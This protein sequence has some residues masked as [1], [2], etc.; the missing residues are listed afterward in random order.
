MRKAAGIFLMAALALAMATTTALPPTVV[1]AAT[2]SFGRRSRFLP[3]LD[4]SCSNEAP[5][6]DPH[7]FH[8]PGVECCDGV[9][10]NTEFN[11]NHCGWCNYGCDSWPW[12]CCYGDCVNTQD[13]FENCGS[14][15]NY[16]SDAGCFNGV[17]GYAV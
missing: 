11:P 8:Y 17:C 2:R 7:G 14:C 16:C 13:D 15:G 4:Y 5:C 10:V 9:C 12:I 3:S 1:L 6:V